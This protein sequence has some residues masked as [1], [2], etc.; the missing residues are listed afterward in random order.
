MTRRRLT[1]LDAA[2]LAA[3]RPG[4]YL[5]MMGVL[6]LDPSTVPGGY[7]FESFRE[8]LVERLPLLAPLRRRLVEVPGGLGPPLWVERDVDLDLHVRRAAL[9]SP[10]GP[11]ELAAM[12]GEMLERPL[13]RSRP[14][15]EMKLVERLA[16]DR[17]ALLAKLHHAMMDGLAGIS[18]MASL[19]ATTAQIAPPPE[20]PRKR[21]DRVPSRLELLAGSL[22]WL[23]RQPLRATRAGAHTALSVLKRAGSRA[24][25][26]PAPALEIPRSWL[27]VE[28]TSQRAVAYLSLPLPEMRALGRARDATVNDVLLTVVAGAVRG[29][30]DARDVLSEQPLVAGVPVAV[31]KNE[32]DTRANA[33]SSVSVG[34]ATDVEDPAARLVAIRDAMA[35]RKRERGR[36]LGEDLA[37]WADVPPPL[38]FSFIADLYLNLHLAERIEPVCNL[39]V[40]SVPGPPEPL[41]LAGA[42][43]EGIY[44]LGPIYSGLA[45]NVTAIGCGD[46]VD[47]GLVAC[48]GRMPDLWELA[49]AMPGE[50]KRLAESVSGRRG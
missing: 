20:V 23:L 35:A 49:D 5:H 1:G 48:R 47:I 14:L 24:S 36:S 31:R 22:P 12:A 34:L 30:L 46:S 11:R 44:P 13:D 8:F 3:E 37:A 9:P 10:G 42:R 39:I 17:I 27:N 7:C 29:Y 4:N 33:V 32:D 28:T 43:L 2:F 45:L 41:Y 25:E 21:P 26:S 50:L 6:I 18:L 40:S 15:W 38:V 19:F 16:G